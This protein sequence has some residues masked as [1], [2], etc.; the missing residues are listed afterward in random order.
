MLP[1]AKYLDKNRRFC[2]FRK[3]KQKKY[4]FLRVNQQ[5]IVLPEQKPHILPKEMHDY[6]NQIWK[7]QNIPRREA[8]NEATK[9]VP[10][11]RNEPARKS[12]KRRNKK[13][14]KKN[15][16]I[17]EE[18]ARFRNQVEK[19]KKNAKKHLK[20]RKIM[21]APFFDPFFHFSSKNVASKRKRKML[22]R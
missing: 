16:H 12:P 6:Q 18:N 4:Y 13:T 10:I 14:T 20:S 8:K 15:T 3:N 9:K 2:H 11:S 19:C 21:S 22:A 17:T 1:R 7:C 5:K